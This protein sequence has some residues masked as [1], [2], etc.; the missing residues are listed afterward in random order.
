MRRIRKMQEINGGSMAD[1]AFLLLIFFL[2]ATTI[3][4]DSGLPRRLPPPVQ[5]DQKTEVDIKKRN[6]MVVLINKSDQLL[7]QGDRVDISQ[8][9]DRAKEFMLNSADDPELPEKL[10]VD[11][12]FFG[13]RMVAKNSVISLQN[14]RGTSYEAYI[15]VQNE[16]DA[17]RNE[18]R[19][20]ISQRKWNKDYS[21]LEKEKQKAVKKIIPTPISEAEPKN[22]GGE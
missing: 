16:L 11:V 1:I 13:T 20:Q 12:P 17:A 5:D 8:L 4:V 9:R 3:N 10:P 15:Q 18:L 21:E 7:V 19:N 6:I 14:D 2:V 22:L